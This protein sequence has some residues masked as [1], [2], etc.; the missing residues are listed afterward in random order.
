MLGDSKDRDRRLRGHMYKIGDNRDHPM[1]ESRALHARDKAFP[2][3]LGN[4]NR[5][6]SGLR[7]GALNRVTK[8]STTA[9]EPERAH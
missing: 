9:V 1:P 5:K 7:N 6:G 8:P 2:K 3:P 4:C